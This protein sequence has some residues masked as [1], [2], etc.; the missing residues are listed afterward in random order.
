[1]S[2]SGDASAQPTPPVL[3]LDL[4]QAD[5]GL[6]VARDL[7]VAGDWA[8]G[9]D[10]VKAAGRDWELRGRRIV[11]LGAATGD[12][13]DAWLE[14]EPDDAVAA[15]LAAERLSNWAGDARGSASAKHTTQA[16]FAAFADLSAQAEE[17]SW[18]AIKLAPDD[19]VPWQTVLA[20][21]FA[22]GRQHRSAFVDAFNQAVQRDVFNFDTHLTRMTYFCAKWFGSHEEMFAAARNVAAAA[23]PGA[24]VA[25]LPFLAHFEFA[26]REF[27]FDE[28]SEASFDRWWDY[29]HRDDVQQEL[30]SCVAKW[31]SR[32][33]RLIGRGMTCRHWQAMGYMMAG[34][35]EEAKQ[36]FDEIGP[37]LGSTPAWGYLYSRQ[38]EGFLAGWRWV[39]GVS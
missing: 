34:R 28:R 20:S 21:K 16:Q 9:R 10:V 25:M 6:R 14:H 32:G 8:A 36:A 18:R 4:A 27:G 19:P 17:A 11:V 13:L 22:G 24:T 26:L 29:F 31:R 37:Y 3:D 15:I 35:K 23:P 7:A 12:W 39:N 38:S 30:D 2:D 1:M 33:A 5:H